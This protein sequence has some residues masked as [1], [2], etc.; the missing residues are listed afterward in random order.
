MNTTEV[1]ELLISNNY[2]H[3]SYS[4]NIKEMSHT[5]VFA[6]SSSYPMLI[7]LQAKVHFKGTTAHAQEAIAQNDNSHRNRPQ[8]GSYYTNPCTDWPIYIDR[9]IP[10]WIQT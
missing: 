6:C 4:S 3:Q 8:A 1:E 2:L 10:G 9:H 7:N 5:P